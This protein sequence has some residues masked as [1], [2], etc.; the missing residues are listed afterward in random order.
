MKKINFLWFFI[1]LTSLS[2]QSTFFAP[3][4]QYVA[5]APSGACTTSQAIQIVISTGVI[6]TCD[7]GTWAATATGGGGV[8]SLTG[9][10]TIFNNSASTGAVTLTLANTPTGTGSV[11]L[12]TSPTLITPILG[13]A[14]ATTINKV[15][16]T[17]PATG[18]TFTI[19]DGKTLTDNNSITFSG[20]DATIMTFPASSTTIAGLGIAQTFTAAQTNSTAGAS[21]TPAMSIT[22]AP[23]V[24]SGTTSTPQLY[25]NGGTA[26]TTWNSTAS[27]GTYLGFNGIASFAGNY[28]D[29]HANGGASIFSLTSNGSLTLSGNL[30]LSGSLA[31]QSIA[32]STIVAMNSG[33]A[34]AL[35]IAATGVVGWSSTAAF[36]G[37]NDTTLC[38]SAAGVVEIGANSGCATTGSVSAL[39]IIAGSVQQQAASNTG[40]TCTMSTGTTCTITI[41]HTYTTP[42]CIVTLQNAA[43]TADATGHSCSVSG[44]TV[45]ITAGT[46]NSATWGAFVFGNPS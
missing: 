41:G 38:R 35:R 29:V 24:G 46:T 25:F 16:L 26:P 40:G 31:G 11:V 21:S 43:A 28:I 8:S 44:T 14:V 4:V 10:G 39:G 34:S 20:T 2:G 33:T 19:A 12:A 36:N 23:F 22:G 15:T 9:D 3:S 32:S 18:S 17:A 45:T 5:S 13:A 7:N 37:G 30:T 1:F 27:G 6:Y 42:V